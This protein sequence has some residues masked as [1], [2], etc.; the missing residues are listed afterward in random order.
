MKRAIFLIMAVLLISGLSGCM[1]NKPGNATTPLNTTTGM[2]S[3][4]KAGEG[5]KLPDFFNLTSESTR[6]YST[7]NAGD[8][9]CTPGSKI[10]VNLPSGEKEY[11]IT[12]LT[13]YKDREVCRAELKFENGTSV[14]YFSKDGRFQAMVSN[15]SG[16]GSVHSEASTAVSSQD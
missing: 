1:N 3:E 16:Q 5:K 2:E 15:A 6:N 7:R 11:T 10:M 14:K 12:G 9:W 4:I 8:G 13:T